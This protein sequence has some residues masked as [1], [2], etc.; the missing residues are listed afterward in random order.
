MT[1]EEGV[2]SLLPTMINTDLYLH[3]KLCKFSVCGT[4]QCTTTVRTTDMGLVLA[5]VGFVDV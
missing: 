2:K 3:C 1:C 4:S 5:A